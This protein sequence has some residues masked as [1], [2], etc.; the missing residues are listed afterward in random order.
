MY[1]Y[2]LSALT[3]WGIYIYICNAQTGYCVLNAI[4]LLVLRGSK[5]FGDDWPG[6]GDHKP[7]SGAILLKHQVLEVHFP[8][9]L[10]N[11]SAWGYPA[12]FQR[13]RSVLPGKH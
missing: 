7:A 4:V 2:I 3:Q 10:S 5:T 11:P 6:Q 8:S 12:R 9:S 1:V 13:P